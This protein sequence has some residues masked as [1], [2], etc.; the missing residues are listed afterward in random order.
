MLSENFSGDLA[1]PSPPFH[2]SAIT[3]RRKVDLIDALHGDV[4]GGLRT[5]DVLMLFRYTEN[6][7]ENRFFA[8]GFLRLGGWRSAIRK[9]V[10]FGTPD[11]RKAPKPG[12]RPGSVPVDVADAH[13]LGVKA[14]QPDEG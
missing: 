8:P 6:P 4:C 12:S 2:A 1:M 9:T 7:P 11:H 5:E 3:K 10:P 14:G 13:A